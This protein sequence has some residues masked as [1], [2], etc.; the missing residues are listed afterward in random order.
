MPANENYLLI[1]L[2][3][4]SC[5]KFCKKVIDSHNIN[6]E[7]QKTKIELNIY[8]K[9]NW[10]HA[11]S[12][13]SKRSL[14]DKIAHQTVIKLEYKETSETSDIAYS[15]INFNDNLIPLNQ[16]LDGLCNGVIDFCL[17]LEHLIINNYNF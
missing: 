16:F 6:L 17:F 3:I 2:R 15:Y 7:P 12:S 13:I 4:D 14:R 10:I 11:L 1:N 8:D 5:T 9:N